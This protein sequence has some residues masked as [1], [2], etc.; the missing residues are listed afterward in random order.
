MLSHRQRVLKTFSFEPTDHAPLDLMEGCVW[1]ELMGYFQQKYNLQDPSA[2]QDFLDTDFRWTFNTYQGPPPVVEAQPPEKSDHHSKGVGAG[3]LA[4][5]TT[6]AEV[7]AYPWPD[8]AYW[9]PGDYAA[10]ARAYPDHARV[11]CIGWSP[12]F[13]GACEAFGMEEALIKMK[14]EPRVFAAY[15]R[16]QNDFYLDILER[17]CQAAEGFC[18]IC[19]LGDDYASQNGLLM[20]PE[21]WRKQIKPHLAAQVQVAHRHGMGVLFH[22]CGSVRAILPDMIDIGINALLVFQTTARGM[23]ARSIAR[24]FGGKMVFYGGMD[25][26]HLL[27]SGTPEAVRAE[28]QANIRAFEGCGGYI[29]ANS[30]HSLASIKGENIEAMLQAAKLSSHP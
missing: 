28:V 17:C 6:S 25:I 10:F 9:Q 1:P 26:Q 13:W 18:D 11:L 3:P 5:A 14:T 8:P 20:S 15:V 27:S 19:W 4:Y 30:H 29:V 21:L 23:D 24:D 12:L 7:E 2:V 22:S 16:R